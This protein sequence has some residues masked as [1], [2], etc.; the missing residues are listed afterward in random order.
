MPAGGGNRHPPFVGS[1]QHV[2]VALLKGRSRL[3]FAVVILGR[4][5]SGCI[6]VCNIEGGLL[7]TT[8]PNIIIETLEN[9]NLA[10][11]L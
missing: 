7:I 11:L 5:N 3:Q 4:T 9:I 8:S 1:Y 2:L 6:H 10:V